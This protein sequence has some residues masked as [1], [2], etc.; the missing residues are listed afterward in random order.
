MTTQNLPG[1]LIAVEGLD[2]SGKST[3]VYLLHQ[4]LSGLGYRTFFSEWNSSTLVKQAT[5]RGKKRHRVFA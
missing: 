3:Q 1:I 4:W 2:G 5:R